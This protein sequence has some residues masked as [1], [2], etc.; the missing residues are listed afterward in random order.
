VLVAASDLAVH[1]VCYTLRP[2]MFP[3]ALRPIVWPLLTAFPSK[4]L[5]NLRRGRSQVRRAGFRAVNAAPSGLESGAGHALR[6]ARAARA[7]PRRRAAGASAPRA[8]S[9]REPRTHTLPTL[10][11]RRARDWG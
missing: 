11:P 9:A 5:A 6:S 8:W 3:R 4:R 2:L 1:S 10:A 7:S